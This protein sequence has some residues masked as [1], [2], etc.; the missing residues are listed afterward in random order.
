MLDDKTKTTAAEMAE[1]DDLRQIHNLLSKM[2]RREEMVL[3]LRFGLDD[4]EPM[5]LME[6]GD[7]LG[8]TRERIRQIEKDALGKLR[9]ELEAIGSKNP[10]IQETKW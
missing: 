3:R 4:E 9:A 8:L 1:A 6:I 10:N 2:E 7:R 5:T